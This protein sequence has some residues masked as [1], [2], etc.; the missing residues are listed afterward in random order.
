MP[1]HGHG[2]EAGIGGR[3]V[4]RWAMIRTPSPP[5]ETKERP[6][7]SLEVAPAYF[8]THVPHRFVVKS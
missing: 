5:G 7:S 1:E 3:T 6:T 4:I 8:L 2:V